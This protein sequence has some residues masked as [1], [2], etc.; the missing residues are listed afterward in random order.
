MSFVRSFHWIITGWW[1]LFYIF[2]LHNQEHKFIL[3]QRI[4]AHFSPGYFYAYLID[5]DLNRCQSFR[6]FS[7]CLSFVGFV[8]SCSLCVCGFPSSF[9]DHLHVLQLVLISLPVNVTLCVFPVCR[10]C[11]LCLCTLPCVTASPAFASLVFVLPWVFLVHKI[12]TLILKVYSIDLFSG[13]L[14]WH[15]S[16]LIPSRFGRAF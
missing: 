15:S 16:T 11:W 13:L 10:L 7:F 1:A 2:K 6:S 9:I 5:F 8:M 14:V 12:A 3:P 4:S